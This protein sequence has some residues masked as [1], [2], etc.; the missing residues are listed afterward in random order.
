MHLM[1]VTNGNSVKQADSLIIKL[2]H[3]ERW[4]KTFQQAVNNALNLVGISQNNEK[5][6][7]GRFGE[8]KG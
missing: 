2:Q 3:P 5:E 8:L 6:L 1:F 4:N 7:D